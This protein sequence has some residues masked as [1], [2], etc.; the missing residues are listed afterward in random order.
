[1]GIAFKAPER[2]IERLMK[3][4]DGLNEGF[5]PVPSV[6]VVDTSGKIEYEYINPN[7]KTRLGADFLLAV[8]KKF[9]E[10]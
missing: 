9:M 10:I 8:L 6:F 7:Y 3:N 5:L 2:Y 1:M 4:S